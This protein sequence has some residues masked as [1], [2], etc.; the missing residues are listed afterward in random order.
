MKEKT[1]IPSFFAQKSVA[2]LHPP[3]WSIFQPESQAAGRVHHATYRSVSNVSMRASSRSIDSEEQFV[4]CCQF[5]DR[6]D[7]DIGESARINR[8]EIGETSGA[9]T[10]KRG[11]HRNVGCIGAV[12]YQGLP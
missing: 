5:L 6:V 4:L 7:Q 8:P 12:V 9:L 11:G 1:A 10:G 2:D 3:P